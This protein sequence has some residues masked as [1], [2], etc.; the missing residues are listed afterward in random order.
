[1]VMMMPRHNLLHSNTMCEYSDRPQGCQTRLPASTIAHGTAHVTRA[2]VTPDPPVIALLTD[3]GTTD[4]Y[5]G[6][7]KAVMLGICPQVHLVDLTHAI[8]PQDVRQAALVLGD[9]F[10]YFP[11]GTVFLVVVDPG[12]GSQRRQIAARVGSHTFV[13]PDN[14]VLSYVIA[15]AA[16]THCV[17]LVNP[18]YRLPFVSRTFHGRDIFAPA[19]AHLA[20]GVPLES[21]G[22]PLDS[23]VKLPFPAVTVGP[24]AIHGEVLYIDHFGNIVTSIGRLEWLDAASTLRL[25]PR[26]GGD[27]CDIAAATTTVTLGSCAIQGIM[28]SYSANAPGELLALVGSAGWLEIAVNQGNAADGVAVTS[29]MAVTL[30]LD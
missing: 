9:S 12:V 27:R 15:D 5:V 30:E 14:G 21:F 19:A 20:C 23:P 6:V 26:F 7:M 10:A 29:G 18:A 22:P 4:T 1:M 11:P 24:K 3:F 13:A 28:P 2:I 16:N 8:S 25:T 17:E